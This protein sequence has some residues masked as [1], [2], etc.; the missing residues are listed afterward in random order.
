MAEPEVGQ[1][2]VVGAQR[3][4]T[5]SLATALE[6]HPQVAFAQPRRPEPKFFLTPGSADQVDAYLARFY[7]DVADG[8]RLR[9]E[10]STS[11]LGSD[12]AC[13]EIHRAF[14]DAHVVVLLRDPVDRAVSHYRFSRA[15]GAE[16][17]PIE[18]A[19]DP[20]AEGRRWDTDAISVSPFHYLS[21]GRYVDDLRR[22]TEAFAADRLHVLLLEDLVA[23]PSGFDDLLGS[24]GLDPL[25]ASG[26]A[27]DE[28]HNAGEGDAVLDDGTRARLAAWFADANADLAELLGRPITRWT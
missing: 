25:P 22:W 17:L 14:P 1:A 18:A 21:R 20:A 3:C 10:K 26:F 5:T 24:L 13:A 23:D 8:T 15:G 9:C 28:R 4:G 7:P 19:L 2:F 16:D 27:P 11:Y 6:A 12:V